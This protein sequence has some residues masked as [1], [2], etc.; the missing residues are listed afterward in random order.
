GS[1]LPDEI[2][3]VFQVMGA[4]TTLAGVVKKFADVGGF[5]ERF[6]GV[7]AECPETHAG[8]VEQR[9]TVGLA[10]L[11][12]AEGQASVVLGNMCRLDRVKH[13]QVAIFHQ[14]MFS[15]EGECVVQ[16]LGAAVDEIPGF[17]VEG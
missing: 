12:P 2:P 4:D 15:A 3:S 8:D 17:A 11:R 7:G 1:D 13:S 16:S 10:A 6:D 14:I 9:R 5:V